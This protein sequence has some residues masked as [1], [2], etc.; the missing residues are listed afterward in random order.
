MW[1]YLC[2]KVWNKCE[3][4]WRWF[5]WIHEIHENLVRTLWKWLWIN[6]VKRKCEVL[7]KFENNSFVSWKCRRVRNMCEYLCS[8]VEWCKYLWKSKSVKLEYALILR[9]ILSL[10][11]CVKWIYLWKSDANISGKQISLEI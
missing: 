6:S 7:D 2:S 11:K 10:Q 9:T 3:T 1:E 4:S 5:I 8:K